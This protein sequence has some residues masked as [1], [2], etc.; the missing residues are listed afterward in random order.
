MNI[1]LSEGYRIT[2]DAYQ[3]I[4]HTRYWATDKQTKQPKEAW[5]QSY[6]PTL[7]QVAK[8]VCTKELKTSEA[9]DLNTLIEVFKNKIEDLTVELEAL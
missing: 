4:L 3:Y 6:H 7:N 8:A 2:S 1:L 9:E 5:T